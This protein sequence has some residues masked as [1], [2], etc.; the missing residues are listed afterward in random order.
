MT[1]FIFGIDL[2]GTR[3][4]AA[5]L[6]RDL[7]ILAR[8]E[9]PTDA[10]RGV[11]DTIGRMVDLVR[12]ITPQMS[13]ADYVS[14]IGIS[15]PGPANP[16]TGYLVAP[17][18]LPGWYNVPLM[19][20]LQKALGYSTFLGNDANVAA[21]AEAARGA[22]RGYRHVIFITISTGIG[23]GIISDGRL[24]LGKA[25][26]GAEVGHI[27][28][29][30]DGEV[31][32]LERAAAG[33]ALARQARQRVEAGE[34]SMM[35]DLVNGNPSEI[36]G[37][38]VGDAAV[39]GDPLALEIVRRAGRVIGIGIASLLHV[40]NPEIVVLGGGVSTLGDLLFDPIREAMEGH[41]ID[42]AYVNELRLKPAEL[43]ENVSLIGAAA[44]VVTK[45]GVEDVA[46][47]AR[48]LEA[49]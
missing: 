27:N 42:K 2:G 9:I 5:L 13:E 12:G 44:L 16:T 29:I 17:P 25:G 33:P 23:G 6:D 39:A 15:A 8:R 11:E 19:L 48:K 38:T 49:E 34:K 18:N 3:L 22:A 46:S 20:L 14:G 24:L 28:I 41:V 36:N 40:F 35:R 4:R 37:K 45:G 47:V 43:G 1:E 31:T 26:L 30:L 32:T 21:L 7:N 10:E